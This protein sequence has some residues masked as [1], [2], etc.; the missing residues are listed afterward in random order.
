MAKIM[1]EM[2]KAQEKKAERSKGDAKI[3]FDALHDTK[4][5]SIQV[6][7]DGCGDSGQINDI[8][9][10]DKKGKAISQPSGKIK[11]S[12][13]SK[14]STWDDKRKEFVDLPPSEATFNELVEQICYDRLGAHHAGWEINEGSYGTFSFD[15]SNRKINLEYN[16]RVESVRTSSESF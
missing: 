3:L 5:V 15:V 11:G 6:D 2:R 13:I 14:G 7:F 12:E 10:Y 8:H 9:Y 16:E 1:A 4:V